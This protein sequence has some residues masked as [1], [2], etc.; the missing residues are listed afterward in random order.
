M[1]GLVSSMS[2]KKD[3]ATPNHEKRTLRKEQQEGEDGAVSSDDLS[4]WLP[5]ASMTCSFPLFPGSSWSLSQ[6]I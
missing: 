6:Y 2:F 1:T 4:L 3:G 5:R